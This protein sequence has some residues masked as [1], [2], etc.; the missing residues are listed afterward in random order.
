MIDTA[1]VLRSHE[2]SSYVANLNLGF[3]IAK[4]NGLSN[5]ENWKSVGC[6]LTELQWLA[7]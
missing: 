1:Y 7:S 3:Q 6:V 4:G 2:G 5:G